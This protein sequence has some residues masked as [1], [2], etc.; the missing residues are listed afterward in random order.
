MIYFYAQIVQD[1]VIGSSFRCLQRCP[2]DMS[3]F[4]HLF[5][6]HFLN[7]DLTRCSKLILYFSYPSLEMCPFF[8][9]CWFF[10]WE[11]YFIKS[12]FF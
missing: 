10:F 2:F 8:E 6:E 3:N 7:P 1:L 4:I 5:F 11:W 12:Y 9:E